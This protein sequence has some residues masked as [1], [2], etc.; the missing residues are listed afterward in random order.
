MCLV[1]EFW[2]IIEYTLLYHSKPCKD[3]KNNY[4]ANF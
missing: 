2:V 4:Y 3:E 1:A